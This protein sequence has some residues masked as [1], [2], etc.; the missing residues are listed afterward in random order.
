MGQTDALSKCVRTSP[1]AAMELFKR[2]LNKALYF[3]GPS[4]CQ[5]V[6]KLNVLCR[7]HPLCSK[8]SEECS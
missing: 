1:M 2:T 7:L 8:S 6:T 5:D 4:V 3:Y